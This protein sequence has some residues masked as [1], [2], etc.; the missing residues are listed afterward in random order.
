MKNYLALIFGVLAVAILVVIGA[1]YYNPGNNYMPLQLQTSS[2]IGD[3]NKPS[4]IGGE[5][6]QSQNAASTP[7][8]LT[9][10]SP[11]NGASVSTGSVTL[12][13]KTVAN[14]DVS[15]NDTDVKADSSGNFSAS[16]T[17]DE[18]ENTIV[19]VAND[20]NGNNTEA[21]ITVTYDSGQ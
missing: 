21:E 8:V 13:G 11:A 4:Q 2:T 15:V 18:G 7:V 19:V 16:V 14:A 3:A 20:S 5:A 6:S 17:L 9:I 1:K 12:R 10:T